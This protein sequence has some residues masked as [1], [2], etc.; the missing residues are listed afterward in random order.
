MSGPS[1]GAGGAKVDAGLAAKPATLVV[2]A[3]SESF[4]DLWPALAAEVGLALE[5]TATVPKGVDPTRTVVLLAAGGEE[6]ALARAA[7]ELRADG[8]VM[9]AAIAGEAGHRLAA[10]VIRAGADQLFVIPEDLDL[11]R[12]WMK[13][14]AGRILSQ[15]SRRAF[16]AT[17]TQKYTF[18]G[19]LGASGSLASALERVA[20]VIPHSNV[21]VLIT[22]ETGTGKELIA[23]AIHYNGP[24][25]ESPFVDI[26][27]AALPEHLL[28]SDLFGHEKGAFTDASSTKPGLFEMAQGGS[29]FLDEIGHLALPLQGK[30]LRAL[31][32]RSIR[33]VGGV[34]TIAIDVRVIAATHVNLEAAVRAGEFREDRY[35]RLNVLQVALPP[36]RNRHE[37]IVPLAKHFLSKF[38][39][40]YGV[41]R[42]E[43]S[44]RAERAL[45]ER[46]WPGNIRE[47]RN[48]IERSI[49]LASK[50][51]LEVEDFEFETARGDG[52]TADAAA[53]VALADIIKQA[54]QETLDRCGGNKSEAARRLGI[55]RPRLVRLLEGGDDE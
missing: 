19:I 55:S 39:T 51:V 10:A 1:A 53:P 31:Q 46:S 50:P 40:E 44:A 20:R 15:E 26:N 16:A 32:E 11:L 2:C 47:L 54:V 12:T 3:M 49:L 8:E 27:C 48:V 45:R 38:A 43:L 17:E 33:R 25:R 23:R 6:A 22:G 41:K 52:Q 34:R 37:D 5:R 24:R 36:L 7:R 21:T 9:F 18:D 4:G 29:I 13:E 14:A 35:S 28:E 30:L 42:P